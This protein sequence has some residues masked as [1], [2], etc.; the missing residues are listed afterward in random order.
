MKLTVRLTLILIV[1]VI[2]LHLHLLLSQ[3]GLKDH[4]VHQGV[5]GAQ[6]ARRKSI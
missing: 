4:H 6:N 1:I 2:H 5:K 3:R